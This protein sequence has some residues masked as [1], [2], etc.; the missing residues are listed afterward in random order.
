MTAGAWGM[1]FRMGE[2][3][4]LHQRTWKQWQRRTRFG[5]ENLWKSWSSTI[6][7]DLGNLKL[8]I[9]ATAAVVAAS[10]SLIFRIIRSITWFTTTSRHNRNVADVLWMN[11]KYLLLL[12][13]LGPCWSFFVVLWIIADLH[14]YYFASF[15]SLLLCLTVCRPGMNRS[16]DGSIGCSLVDELSI[17]ILD[18]CCFIG[19]WLAI[20]DPAV[21]RSIID[22]NKQ[23]LPK[24][25]SSINIL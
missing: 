15:A 1:I 18:G 11:V 20:V 4:W 16:T 13:Y 17:E 12:Y 5:N 19:S 2:G 22:K 14:V 7:F 21:C 25:W 24:R 6:N 3:L 8:C 10:V 9:D 23:Q